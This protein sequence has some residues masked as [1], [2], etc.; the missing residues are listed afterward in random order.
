MAVFRNGSGQGLADRRF[1]RHGWVEL[2]I[3]FAN[4]RTPS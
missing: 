2:K 4:D 3:N 1:L